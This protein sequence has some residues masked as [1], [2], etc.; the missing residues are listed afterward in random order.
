MHRIVVEPIDPATAV[1][2]VG[3]PGIG[4]IAVFLG[5]VREFNAG[6]EVTAVE[7]HAYPAMAEKEML[8]ITEA[9]RGELP[10]IRVAM[11]HRTGRLRVGETSLVV[12]VGAPHRREAFAGLERA[13]DRIKRTVPVWKK[14]F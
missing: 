3:G 5:V 8:R 9:L 7:Y 10:G 2:E 6:R 12:A 13:V 14:E 11:I 4:G 1:A